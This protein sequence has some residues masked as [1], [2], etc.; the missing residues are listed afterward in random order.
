[1]GTTQLAEAHRLNRVEFCQRFF[2]HYNDEGKALGQRISKGYKFRVHH[3]G[4]ELKKAEKEV[5]TPEIKKKKFRN[6]ICSR[7][8]YTYY[9]ETRKITCYL[10]KGSTLT[11]VGSSKKSYSTIRNL[12]F[13][14]NAYVYCQ[15]K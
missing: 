13:V 4:S 8:S 15:S 1:M 6:Q 12:Q 5:G 7:K 3:F 11:S 2:N 14:P 9:F 10:E